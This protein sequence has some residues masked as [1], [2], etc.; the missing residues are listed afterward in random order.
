MTNNKLAEKI[1]NQLAA[2]KIYNSPAL[3][4]STRFDPSVR[5]QLVKEVAKVIEKETKNV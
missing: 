5:Q 1:I 2:F 3:I 4:Y